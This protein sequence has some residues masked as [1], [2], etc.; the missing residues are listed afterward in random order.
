MA[1]FDDHAAV[2]AR[3][4]YLVVAKLVDLV[5]VIALAQSHVGFPPDPSGVQNRTK[6]EADSPALV[7]ERWSRTVVTP[8]H[9]RRKVTLADWP[10]C[11][12]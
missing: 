10:L 4:H 3:H 6:A 9:A 8:D 7:S 12:A 1:A 5:A 11:R 2:V